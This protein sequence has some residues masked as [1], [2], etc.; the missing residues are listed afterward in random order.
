[1]VGFFIGLTFPVIAIISDLLWNN[2]PFTSIFTLFSNGPLHWIIL[3]APA[4]FG[5]V[6]Y[7]FGKMAS[8]YEEVLL[9]DQ[10]KSKDMLD[11]LELSIVNI[12]RGDYSDNGMSFEN[13]HLTVLLSSLKRKLIDQREK[14]EK[15]KWAAEGLARFGELFRSTSDLSKLSDEVIKNL[16]RYVGLNQGSIFSLS[17]TANEAKTLELTTCYAYDK[18]KYL[19]RTIAIDEGLVGQCFLESSPIVL[20]KV[21]QDYVKITSGLGA[22]NPDF[23][24]LIPIKANDKME[25]VM[26]LAGFTP[27]TDDQIAFIEKVCEGFASV[28]RSVKIN[29]ETKELLQATQSQTEELRSQEEEMRQNMEELHATQEA[30]ERK[31]AEEQTYIKK[32][33]EQEEVMKRNILDLEQLQGRVARREEVMA[34]T[35]ILSET[36]LN[37]T[38]TYVNDKFCT[39]AKYKREELLGKPHNIVRHPDMPKELFRLFWE[40]IKKGEVFTGIVKNRAKDGSPYWVDATIVPIKNKEGKV[41]KYTG[42]RYYITDDELGLEQYNKQADHFG[43]PRLLR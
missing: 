40:T 31:L 7:Y 36:D 11:K 18:K 26:E 29:N 20:R 13:R 32:L 23:L 42:A 4:V 27:L 30:M 41:I 19:N 9:N 22:A 1:M 12:E 2:L 25:G 37:G 10:A 5:L 28:M 33:H 35:T 16:V 6:F 43:W 17:A 24:L 34:L 39:V 14:D 38:I 8:R 15:A 21:P 3:C